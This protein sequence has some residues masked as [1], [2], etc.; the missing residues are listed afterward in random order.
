MEFLQSLIM[1]S[2]LEFYTAIVA[3]AGVV[4]WFIDRKSMKA[5]LASAEGAQAISL[6][7]ERLAAEAKVQNSLLE[8]EMRCQMSRDAWFEHE[9]RCG[10]RLV[11]PSFVSQE[12]KETQR[13]ERTG[14]AL[15]ERFAASAPPQ[16]TLNYDDL[17][18][19]F[20]AASRTS[21]E[22]TKLVSFVPMPSSR[23]N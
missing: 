8:L 11:A 9:R 5:A 1:T 7:L 4:F 12:Q 3:T 18:G 23:L 15:L 16:E 13:L 6:R 22:I 20:V 19:Y 10:P 17:Q 2:P 14:R 21:H